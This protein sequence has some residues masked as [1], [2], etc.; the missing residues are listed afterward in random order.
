MC[1]Q[2]TYSLYPQSSLYRPLE[3]SDSRCVCVGHDMSG[4]QSLGMLL[5]VRAA[6]KHPAQPVRILTLDQSWY[7]TWRYRRKFQGS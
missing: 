5:S 3:K 4:M 6:I 1:L 7:R 2:D